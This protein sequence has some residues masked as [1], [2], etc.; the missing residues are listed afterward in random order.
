MAIFVA[1][2]F[3]V[4]CVTIYLAM[5]AVRIGGINLVM[6]R[7]EKAKKVYVLFGWL[8]SGSLFAL[9]LLM[10][11]FLCA[12]IVRD[13]AAISVRR[14]STIDGVVNHI[15]RRFFSL[16]IDGIDDPFIIVAGPFKRI[17]TRVRITYPM[18]SRMILRVEEIP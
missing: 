18:H 4:F 5:E 16:N 14:F 7:V 2:S 1:K 15:D 10:T 13:F 9:F 17:D 11:I 8:S 3:A 6:M 12:P